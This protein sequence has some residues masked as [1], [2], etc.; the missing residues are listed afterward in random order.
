MTA[1][2]SEERREVAERLRECARE[3]NGTRD[4]STCH[5]VPFDEEGMRLPHCSKCGQPILRPWPNFCPNC[6]AR[7]TGGGED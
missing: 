5:V 1:P 6:G 4:F 2:T 7:I 3:V